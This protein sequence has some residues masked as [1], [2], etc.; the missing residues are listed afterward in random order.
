MKE[1]IMRAKVRAKNFV[2]TI[3]ANV[4][5]AKLSDADFRV[6]IRNTLPFVEGV[7]NDDRKEIAREMG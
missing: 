3:A 6:F 4:D 2:Q 5:N 7:A 1:L